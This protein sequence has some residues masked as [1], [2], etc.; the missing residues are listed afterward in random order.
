MQWECNALKMPGRLFGLA[1]GSGEGENR[2][3]VS[4][5]FKA[6]TFSLHVWKSLC[7][8]CT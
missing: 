5:C 2:S 7:S 8:T 4:F 6:Q 3:L 1:K